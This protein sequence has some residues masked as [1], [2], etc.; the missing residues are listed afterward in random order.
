[1][2]TEIRIGMVGLDTSHCEAFAKILHDESYEYH[3]PGARIVAAY[4]GI[5]R[6]FSMSY[7]RVARYT[8]ILHNQYGVALYDD[9][10]TLAADVDAIF[11]ESVDSRQHPEQLAQLAVGKPIFVDKP[12]ATSAAAARAMI[13]TAQRTATPLMSCSSLRY[14]SGIAGLV[15]AD[16]K[17]L[18]A[19]AFGPAVLLD[20][21]PGLFWYGIHSAEVLMVLMGRGCK[22]V[23]CVTRAE[24]DLVVGDWA[25]GRVGVI[26]GMRAGAGRFGCV[27][28]LVS[29]VRCGMDQGT[30][31]G[32][33]EMLRA[34]LPFLRSGEAPIDL[35]E[36]FEIIALLD[37]AE[38]SRAQG[39]QVVALETL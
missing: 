12:L 33:Y 24:M 14:A 2:A 38:R 9:L 18:A 13:E 8:D 31:P 22:R 27:A 15:A 21:F 6:Q 19:E 17:V 26:R 1:M 39:G 16:E 23:Q 35:A 4:P 36:T 10:S 20:D 30:P 5:S 34:V 7:E 32:Y 37:A 29:E 25:D 28:H 3:L 11:L